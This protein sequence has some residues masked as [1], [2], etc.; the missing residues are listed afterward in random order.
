M[1][2]PFAS[3]A[4]HLTPSSLVPAATD[5]S[6]PQYEGFIG[7]ILS[8]IDTLGEIGVGIAVF[9]ETFIPPIPS[10][11]VLPV[12][13]FLAFDG[14]MNPVFA[15]AMATLGALVGAWAWYAIGAALGRDRTRWLIVKIPLMDG[16]DFDKAEKFFQKWGVV[17]VLVGRCVPLVRSFIS[18]PAGIE[19]MNLLKFSAYTALGSGVWNAI[20]IGL[21]Y[22]FGP[23]IRPALE[24]WS[25]ILSKIVVIVIL[26]LVAWFIIARL[27]K[28]SLLKTPQA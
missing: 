19:R 16:E 27:R 28:R 12:A 10:E 6:Q 20:W 14:R 9:A 11:A 7:W 25:G 3:S 15:W 5:P 22:A 24:N 26:A 8:L 18:I 21:G 13:G 1:T 17:A 4:A 2:M 23:A